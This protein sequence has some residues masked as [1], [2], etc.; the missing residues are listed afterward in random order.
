MEVHR[1]VAVAPEHVRLDEIREHETL[2]EFVQEPLGLVDALDVRASRMRLVD[3]DAGEDVPDLPDRV[4]LIPRLAHERQIVRLLGLQRPVVPVRRAH[5]VARLTFE[6]PCDDA[7]DRVLARQDLAR[8]LASPV[9]LLERNRVDV[10]RDLEDGVGR[11]VDDPLAG[12]LMLLPQLLD[13]L[14]AGSRLVPED[15]TTRLVHEGVEH[16]ERKAVRIGRQC[17]WRDDAHQLPVAGRRVLALRAL[18]EPARNRRRAGLRRTA[19]ERLD[20]AEAERLEVREVEAADGASDVPQ[21]VRTFVSER[22]RV[23]Q[24]ARAHRVQHDDACAGHGA[25]LGRSWKPSSGYSA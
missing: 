2:V 19:L 6:R 3:V 7:P 12:S 25:I 5:V 1:V 10:R 23:G 8:D 13:D 14:G 21:R 20:V 22:G 9:E 15:T 24:F 11:G 4:H 16:V 17:R 18:D